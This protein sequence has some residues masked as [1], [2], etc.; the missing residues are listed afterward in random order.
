MASTSASISADNGS[1]VGLRERES[2]ALFLLPLHHSAVKL[3]AMSLVL[4]R[5]SLGFLI[6]SRRY[7]LRIESKGLWSMT[8][9]K[10]CSLDRKIM[11]FK[12]VQHTASISSYIVVY[13]DS[14]SERKHDPA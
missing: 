4:S 2:G 1:D 6:S 3:Q 11:H 14:A 9:V 12:V 8:T 7:E 5:C 10:Y 13:H